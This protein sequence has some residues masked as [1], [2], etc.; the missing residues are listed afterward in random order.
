[1]LK[2]INTKILLAILRVPEH[3]L[4]FGPETWLT[5]PLR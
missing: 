2:A 5:S 3:R 4:H 1:M